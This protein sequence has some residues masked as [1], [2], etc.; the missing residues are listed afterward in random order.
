MLQHVDVHSQNSWALMRLF[1]VVEVVKFLSAARP[2]ADKSSPC[3]L[4]SLFHNALYR[5]QSIRL[6]SRNRSS[7]N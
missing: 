2:N 6:E 3:L 1:G 7:I 5:D 4:Q